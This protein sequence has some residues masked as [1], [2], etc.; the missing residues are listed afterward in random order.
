MIRTIIVEDDPMV[1]QINSQYLSQMGGFRVEAILQNGSDALDFLR[2][3]PVDLVILDMYMPRVNGG[4]VLR[5]MRA[6][7]ILTSVI[8]VTAV[9]DA[10]TIGEALGLGIIDYLIKPYSF[11]RFREA[12][13]KY[14]TK[15]DLIRSADT[16]DQSM[17]DRLLNGDTQPVREKLNKGLNQNTLSSIYRLL[18]LRPDGQH[19]CESLSAASGLSKVTV[20]RYLNY[21]IETGDVLSSIDYETGGRPRVL[22]ELKRPRRE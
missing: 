5:R 17:V 19:T 13:D 18:Q 7:N 12:I 21:L 4:E 14:L 10:K 20:R 3:E 1:A 6:E 8:I 2:R 16:L 22:Y 9:T 15:M 11:T